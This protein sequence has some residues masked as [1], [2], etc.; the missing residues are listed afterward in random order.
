M[1]L[2]PSSGCRQ[3]GFRLGAGADRVFPF[4]L[5]DSRDA[6]NL[7]PVHAISA[8]ATGDLADAVQGASRAAVLCTA[9]GLQ[10]R[11]ALPSPPSRRVATG[12]GVCGVVGLGNGSPLPAPSALQPS[13]SG[14]NAGAEIA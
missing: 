11:N 13:P 6:S 9:S 10:R 5:T 1:D 2:H 12:R 14:G 3:A 4:T 7:G 8:P